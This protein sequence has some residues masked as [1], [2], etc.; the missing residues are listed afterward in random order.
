MFK[1]VAL[2]ES[3]TTLAWATSGPS[4]CSKQFDTSLSDGRGNWA[5]IQ[6]ADTSGS[7]DA[8]TNYPA[9]NY[10]NNYT[11]GFAVGDWYLPSKEELINLISQITAINN[12]ISK[13]PS[14]IVSQIKTGIY[15]SSSQSYGGVDDVGHS[16]SGTPTNGSKTGAY[17]VRAIRA[18]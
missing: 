7:A 11:G 5:V 6:N 9:F 16:S 2:E 4:G 3:S 13:L 12:S 17:Y 10:C 1:I 15:M 8:A 14:E 18:F